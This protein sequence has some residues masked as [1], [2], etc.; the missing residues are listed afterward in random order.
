MVDG[1]TTASGSGSPSRLPDTPYETSREDPVFHKEQCLFC[2]RFTDGLDANVA[3]MQTA[4]G[5]F[6]AD[7]ERLAVDLE[8]LIAYLHLVIAGYNECICCGTQRN[9]TQAVQQHMVGKGHCKFD[10]EMPDSEYADFYTF[11]GSDTGSEEGEDE[12]YAPTST[13]LKA[14]SLS[15]QDDEGSLRL[16]SG[17]TVSNRSLQQTKPRRKPLRSSPHV[18]KER[19]EVAKATSDTRT[20]Q[21]AP[22]ASPE[23]AAAAQTGSSGLALTRAERREHNF[24]KQLA[25]LRASDAGALAHL[26]DSEKRAVLATQQQQLEKEARAEQRYRTRLEGLGNKFLMGHFVKDAADK[27]TLWK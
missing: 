12:D 19:L 14:E 25:S 22:T 23:S 2:N 8:T 18:E 27:R 11:S 24:N 10:I 6:I 17:R 9:T 1:T 26:S 20:R 13:R 7:R 4:H 16:P 5:L 15:V 21:A 3:H